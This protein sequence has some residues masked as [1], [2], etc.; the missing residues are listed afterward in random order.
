MGPREPILTIIALLTAR[1]VYGAELLLPHA[2]KIGPRGNTGQMMLSFQLRM[3]LRKAKL[4]A[5]GQKEDTGIFNLTV[6]APNQH[7]APEDADWRRYEYP[8]ATLSGLLTRVR[9]GDGPDGGEDVRWDGMEL[10]LDLGV[11]HAGK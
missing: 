8:E 6:C 5:H 3:G 10:R 9:D 4:T 2:R 11:P 7:C 1:V